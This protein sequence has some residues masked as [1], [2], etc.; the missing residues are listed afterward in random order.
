MSSTRRSEPGKPLRQERWASSDEFEQGIWANLT[1]RRCGKVESIEDRESIWFVQ[2]MSHAMGLKALLAELKDRFGSRIGTPTMRKL[3]ALKKYNADQVRAVRDELPIPERESFLLNGDRSFLEVISKK[4]RIELSAENESYIRAAEH[5]EARRSFMKVADWDDGLG[6]KSEDEKRP[7][8]YLA[9][10]FMELCQRYFEKDFEK[11]LV[12]FCNDPASSTKGPWYFVE[13][14]DC[15]QEMRNSRAISGKVVTQIGRT[16]DDVLDYT[17]ATNCLSL[18]NGNS[19]IGKSFE[20]KAWCEAH[21]HQARYVEVPSTNDD[22]GFFRAIGK[23][24]GLSRAGSWKAVDLRQR[25]EDVL[26]SG[27]LLIAFDEAHYLWP[28]KDFRSQPSRVT[29]VMTALANHNVPVALI[30]TPQFIRS[31]QA[32]EKA[33]QWTSEQFIGRIGRYVQLPSSLAESDLFKVAEWQLPEGDAKAIEM[34]VRYA[35]GSAKYLAG[36]ESAVKHA[37]YLAGIDG[38]KTA[39]RADIKRAIQEGVIPS[40][41]ALADALANSSSHGK[42]MR[43]APFKEPLTGDLSTDIRPA[44]PHLETNRI[45]KLPQPQISRFE[46]PA[47]G[48]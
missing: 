48:V 13:M 15:L 43:R 33:T 34:L 47:I 28:S 3:G 41:T 11:D 7:D 19:R 27:D 16:I 39:S 42:R 6:T 29:W 5:D 18:T 31:Q 32:V 35:Q 23:S 12:R 36:I 24:L 26:Q 45:S 37:R 44:F 40:D 30:T 1:A 20:V 25:I 8:S 17:L 38:R 14:A 4:E 10:Q 46:A 21:P 9:C 2:H 22:I